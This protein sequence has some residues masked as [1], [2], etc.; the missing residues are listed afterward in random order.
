MP[1]SPMF[2]PSFH[3][4]RLS[5]SNNMRLSR[6]K[7]MRAPTSRNVGAIFDRHDIRDRKRH[8]QPVIGHQSDLAMRKPNPPP[9]RDGV[10]SAV[11][12][13]EREGTKW[14]LISGAP[15][16]FNRHHD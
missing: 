6:R 9:I 13:L 10:R 3:R 15:Q 1:P 4:R 16:L 8:E 5:V 2:Q 12:Q 14:L 11:I 7:Y